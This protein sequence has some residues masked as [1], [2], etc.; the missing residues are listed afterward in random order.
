MGLQG[1]LH[2][3]TIYQAPGKVLGEKAVEVPALTFSVPIVSNA[4]R[5]DNIFSFFLE[6][7]WPKYTPVSFYT[8][9]LHNSSR[10][11]GLRHRGRQL[12][13]TTEKRAWGSKD[14]KEPTKFKGEKKKKKKKEN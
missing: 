11:G 12:G 13:D 3:C 9:N 5:K 1:K 14:R 8:F 4:A 7:C 10:R 2:D 6:A